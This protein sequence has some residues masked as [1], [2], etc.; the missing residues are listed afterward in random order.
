MH[1]AA[2]LS[3]EEQ[4]SPTYH[5][6]DAGRQRRAHHT[7]AEAV[8]KHRVEEDV[9]HRAGGYPHHRITCVTLQTQLVVECQRRHHERCP[10]EDKQQIIIGRRHDV[11]S[12]AH[13]SRKRREQ[14]QSDDTGYRAHRHRGD[15][16][17]GRHLLRLVIFLCSKCRGDEV[18]GAVTE[19]KTDSVDERHVC[20][21]NTHAS[22]RLGA[23]MADKKRI[24]DIVQRR[25]HHG[26]DSR[27]RHLH[28]KLTH[29]TFR[30]HNK[31]CAALLLV[32]FACR[33]KNMLHSAKIQK[34]K[35]RNIIFTIFAGY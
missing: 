5:L 15:E 30:H 22:R 25:H 34:I 17:C 8:D 12:G 26:D 13:H 29:R 31:T 3:A 14:E 9:K 7:H 27:D 28:N 10:D 33:T 35:V 6:T 21:R 1:V 24:D 16:T 11:G 2:S 18:T 23:D 20:E 32:F 19:E 4:H